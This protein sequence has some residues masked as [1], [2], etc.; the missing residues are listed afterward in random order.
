MRLSK[1]KWPLKC[2]KQADRELGLAPGAPV[3]ELRVSSRV[4]AGISIVRPAWPAG[5]ELQGGEA[6]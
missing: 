1:A 2:P 3:C 5:Q 6:A 4:E